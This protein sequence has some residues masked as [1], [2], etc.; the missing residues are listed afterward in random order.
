MPHH[1][2]KILSLGAAACVLLATQAEA[3]PLNPGD[4]F[5]IVDDQNGGTLGVDLN[6]NPEFGLPP[7]ASVS[8][9]AT[10]KRDGIDDFDF[11]TIEDLFVVT[12]TISQDIL[13]GPDGVIFATTF[14]GQGSGIG[15]EP[16][17]VEFYTLSGY[18]GFD[19]DVEYLSTAPPLS[20]FVSD[21]VYPF[22]VS[23]SA[24]GDTITFEASP[25]DPI[26]GFPTG[27]FFIATNAP[28]FATNGQGSAG[29]AVFSFS[30][31]DTPLSGLARPTPI[32]LPAPALLL[33]SGLAALAAVRRFS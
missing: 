10:V 9:T 18:S 4:S 14:D 29:L 3:V 6:T 1:T 32:P 19:V 5:L 11:S 15:T 7:V 26:D 17:G 30:T 12:G 23:R 27:T 25:G 2:I 24:D 8:A 22:V 31:F 33:V 20:Q 16:D 21:V 28:N 13:Q